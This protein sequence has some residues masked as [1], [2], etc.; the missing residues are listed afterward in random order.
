MNTGS[1]IMIRGAA[2]VGVIHINLSYFM[3]KCGDLFSHRDKPQRSS[4]RV[5]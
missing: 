5:M 1:R 3:R 4:E 2:H